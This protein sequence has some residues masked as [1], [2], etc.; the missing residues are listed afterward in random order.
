MYNSL[1]DYKTSIIQ[2]A[3]ERLFF[4]KNINREGKAVQSVLSNLFDKGVL[5]IRQW[6]KLKEDNN[7]EF[8]NGMW[9][10]QHIDFIV[11]SYN[12]LNEENY[13][14]SNVGG[15]SRTYNMPPE[16]VLKSKIPQKLF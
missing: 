4:M 5:I 9:S 12:A 15:V 13:R 7:D 3:E 11:D 14:T 1:E 10:S 6:R 2:S 16:S 8:L